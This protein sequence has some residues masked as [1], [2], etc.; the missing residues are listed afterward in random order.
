MTRNRR[1]AVRRIAVPLAALFVLAA[2]AA[3]VSCA[4]IAGIDSPTDRARGDAGDD[5]GTS[6]DV[7]PDSLGTADVEGSADGG[8]GDACTPISPSPAYGCAT[9]SCFGNLSC[10]YGTFGA[11]C[12]VLPAECSCAQTL[13]CACL[14]GANDP[15]QAL[16]QHMLTCGMDQGHVIVECVAED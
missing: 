7:L 9:G 3:V 12:A 15:C 11:Q 14:V 13:S 8:P 5:A 4:T 16:G 1:A 6:R 10:F 2:P